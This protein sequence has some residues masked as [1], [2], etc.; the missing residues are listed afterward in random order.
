METVK[1]TNIDSMKLY[2]NYDRLRNEIEVIKGELKG[3]KLLAKHLYRFD[4]MHYYGVD[5]VRESMTSVLEKIKGKA[6]GSKPVRVLDFG[7]GLGGPAR[8]MADELDCEVVAVEIQK[9]SS[10][11]GADVTLDVGLSDR[12]T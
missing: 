7:S 9:E 5:S 8:F 11:M 10:D 3:E 4:T 12:V 2:Q 1:A 6:E